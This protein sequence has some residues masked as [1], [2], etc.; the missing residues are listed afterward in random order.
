MADI[1]IVVGITFTTA[2]TFM[3]VALFVI[4]KFIEK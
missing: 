2:I 4:E 1:L 3:A